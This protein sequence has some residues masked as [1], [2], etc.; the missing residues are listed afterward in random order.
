MRTGRIDEILARV[1]VAVEAARNFLFSEQHEDGYWCG[2]LEADTT[3]ESDYILL[4][5]LLGTGDERKFAKAARWIL[6][7]Q[8]EDGGWPIY[9]GGPSNVSATVKAYFGLKLAGYDK[10]FP[11]LA[12]ARERIFA[13]G[14]VTEINTFTKIY[15]CFFG[16][17]DYDAVPAVPP[18]IVLFPNWF[19]FNIYEISSWSRA[20][21]VPLSIAYAKK[22][23]KKIPTEMGIDELFPHGRQNTKLHLHWSDKFV[24]WRNFFLVFDRI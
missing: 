23:F 19:W 20:I 5:R 4:H 17:Y 12:K 18:E 13:M 6:E 22:P 24:S 14:G 11:A 9:E 16:Q 2:E 1:A 7:H 3:L 21:L 8:N 10:D 15:L